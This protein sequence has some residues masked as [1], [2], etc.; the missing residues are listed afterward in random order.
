[1][2]ALCSFETLGNFYCTAQCLIP[3]YTTIHI[4]D[5]ENLKFVKNAFVQKCALW[6]LQVTL[7]LDWK[8]EMN[9]LHCF[10]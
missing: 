2:D 1:M 4:N 3:E 7:P 6:K 9:I 10:I 5:C 8:Y